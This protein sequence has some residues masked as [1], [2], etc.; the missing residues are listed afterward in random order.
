[1]PKKKTRKTHIDDQEWPIDA[2]MAHVECVEDG[3]VAG[4]QQQRT[5][6]KQPTRVHK[7]NDQKAQRCR[8]TETAND[9]GT[10]LECTENFWL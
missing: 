10:G 5:G 6:R 3:S 1:M 2:V 8:D 9:G 4:T 7:R